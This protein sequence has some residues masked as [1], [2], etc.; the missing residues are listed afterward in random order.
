MAKGKANCWVC[1]G[2]GWF[3]VGDAPEDR[4][5]CGC[6]D[7]TEEE[8]QASDHRTPTDEELAADEARAGTSA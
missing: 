6:V 2:E 8:F 3:E 1:D 7:M 5:E 4:L